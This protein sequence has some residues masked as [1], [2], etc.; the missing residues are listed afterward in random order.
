MLDLYVSKRETFVKNISLYSTRLTQNQS[1]S[2]VIHLDTIL[3]LV[4]IHTNFTPVALINLNLNA[5]SGLESN[6]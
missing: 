1:F 4:Y 5:A 3:I 2:K 6:A